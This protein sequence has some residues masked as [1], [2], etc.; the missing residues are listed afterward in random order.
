MT[1]GLESPVNPNSS[2]NVR[3]WRG[4]AIN[5]LTDP[6]RLGCALKHK[7]EFPL[8]TSVVAHSDAIPGF[9]YFGANVRVW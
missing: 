2:A 4:G 5:P 8:S 7:L 9:Q 6:T 3:V 1:N